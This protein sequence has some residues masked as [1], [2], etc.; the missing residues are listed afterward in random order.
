MLSTCPAGAYM[1]TPSWKT[2]LQG[3]SGSR[4]SLPA[5]V[6]HPRVAVAVAVGQ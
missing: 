1:S 2:K 3:R 5:V 6:L 4:L